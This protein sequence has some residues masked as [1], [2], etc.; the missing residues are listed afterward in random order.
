MTG[1]LENFNT[2]DKTSPILDESLNYHNSIL[3]L[4][5]SS[6]FGEKKPKKLKYGVTCLRKNPSRYGD[7]NRVLD[8]L[9]EE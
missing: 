6:I 5:E 2:D 3:T 4:Q 7:L 8:Q 1:Q 9:F